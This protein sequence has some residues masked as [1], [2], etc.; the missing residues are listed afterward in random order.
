MGDAVLLGQRFDQIARLYHL[1]AQERVADALACELVAQRVGELVLIDL[2][3]VDQH[4]A[5]LTAKFAQHVR[6]RKDVR[7]LVPGHVAPLV[8]CA[9]EEC[10]RAQRCESVDDRAPRLAEDRQDALHRTVDGRDEDCLLQQAPEGEKERRIEQQPQQVVVAD[11]RDGYAPIEVVP[12][13]QQQHREDHDVTAECEE[14]RGDALTVAIER[15]AGGGVAAPAQ[16]LPCL[17][18]DAG[19]PA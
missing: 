15:V 4:V 2:V 17:Q 10:E 1:E 6:R 19:N 13:F 14:V 3:L 16:R 9:E 18:A 12:E 5:E 8:E 11:A 7:G